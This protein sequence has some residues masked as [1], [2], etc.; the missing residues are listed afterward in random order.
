M[1][2]SL[3]D[4]SHNINKPGFSGCLQKY[5]TVNLV[6]IGRLFLDID[7]FDEQFCHRCTLF[8]SHITQKP[9]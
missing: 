3:K 1:D 2:A 6:G 7:V 4:L 8:I 9:Q 5:L